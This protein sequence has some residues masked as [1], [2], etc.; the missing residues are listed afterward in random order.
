MNFGSFHPA[1]LFP[2][3]P[4]CVHFST[5]PNITSL[6]FHNPQDP[7]C[8]SHKLIGV[9]PSPGAWLSYQGPW[10]FL[11]CLLQKTSTG[12]NSSVEDWGSLAPLLSN[13]SWSDLMQVL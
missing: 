6:F 12:N 4:R 11:S 3:P 9:E 8:A 1:L 5:L 2:V 7:V 13:V 10:K